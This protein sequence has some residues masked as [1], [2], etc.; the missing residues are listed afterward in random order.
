MMITKI[1]KV[2]NALGITIPKEYIDYLDINQGDY[3]L[4]YITEDKELQIKYM[5]YDI[6]YFTKK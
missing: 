5:K 2:G 3:I 1:R 6:K 4:W